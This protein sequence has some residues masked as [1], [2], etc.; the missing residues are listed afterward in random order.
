METT[1]IP[2]TKE[3]DFLMTLNK[4]L[5]HSDA[6]SA[7]FDWVMLTSDKTKP[8]DVQGERVTDLAYFYDDNYKIRQDFER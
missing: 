7:I 3:K 4:T 2:T 5:K 6:W 1:F 8:I